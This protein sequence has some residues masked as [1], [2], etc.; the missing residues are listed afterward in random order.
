MLHRRLFIFPGYVWSNTC[1]GT[2]WINLT[3]KELVLGTISLS[4]LQALSSRILAEW[5]HALLG[6]IRRFQLRARV[7]PRTK[8]R[9]AGFPQYGFK[10]YF[11]SRPSCFVV[12]IDYIRSSF[13]DHVTPAQC[14]DVVS[15]GEIIIQSPFA[16]FPLQKLP[17]YYELI[18]KS[19]PP[20]ELRSS[21]ISTALIAQDFPN[22]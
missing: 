18:R 9:A 13:I 20:L 7:D 10:W 17:H 16:P 2:C 3:V 22:F 21:L 12:C 15:L 6:C 5:F 8:V 4:I 14:L 1:V 19:C 11:F